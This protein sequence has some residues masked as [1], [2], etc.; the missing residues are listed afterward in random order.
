MQSTHL[1]R[2]APVLASLN[3]AKTIAFYT[4]KLG[5][6]QQF[7]DD[8]Y[9]IVARDEIVIHFWKCDDPIFPQNTSCYVHVR[10]VENLYYEM[11][12][13][14]VIH[15]N[16]PLEDKPRSMREFAILD[17]DGNLIRFGERLPES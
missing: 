3:I 12:V 13:A 10:G 16:G 6:R 9:G 1:H 17:E 5:F 2:A 15:P 4:E 11:Q 7:V 8:N 14:G